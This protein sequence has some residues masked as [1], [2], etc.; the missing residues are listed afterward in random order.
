MREEE[1]I[2]QGVLF[3]PEDPELVA[4]KLKAHNLNIDYNST[5][6]DE[7]VVLTVMTR[8]QAI[9]LRLVLLYLFVQK[10]VF[11]FQFDHAFLHFPALAR[12]PNHL[13]SLPCFFRISRKKRAE[14]PDGQQR[15]H[16]PFFLLYA[17]SIHSSRYTNPSGSSRALGTHTVLKFI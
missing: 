8:M 5:H 12:G 16:Q 15:P 7:T 1:R 2:M 10:R 14:I 13:S 9:H 17:S 11:C 3:Y 4:F 6:E